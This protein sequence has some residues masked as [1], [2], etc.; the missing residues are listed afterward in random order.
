MVL[1]AT[2][3]GAGDFG[4]CLRSVPPRASR[5]SF[6]SVALLASAAVHA[7]AFV[8]FGPFAASG[9]R[10]PAVPAGPLVVQVA[11]APAQVAVPTPPFPPEDAPVARTSAARPAKPALPRAAPAPGLVPR[12]RAGGLA[13]LPPAPEPPAPVA[14]A[15]R[16]PAAGSL[17]LAP[18]RVEP[19]PSV[20]ATV[21]PA[22]YLQTPEPA[23]PEAAREEGE[24]GVVMLSVRISTQ[25]LPAEIVL[26][27]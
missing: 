10:P 26:E 20:P 14:G 18:V 2:A 6:A 21:T 7:A 27:R 8:A 19:R 1:N 15:G 23:Y 5:R 24:E 12:D 16:V 11:I 13:S 9:S 17:A 22:A 4:P 25:G 3:A